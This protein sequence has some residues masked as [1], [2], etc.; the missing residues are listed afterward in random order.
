VVAAI[1]AGVSTLALAGC[2]SWAIPMVWV[3]NVW[4][5]LDLL[6]AIYDGQIGVGIDPG[7]LGAAFFI[8]TVVVP[9]LLVFAWAHLLAATAVKAVKRRSAVEAGS[10][11]EAVMREKYDWI[12][13]DTT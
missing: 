7:S 4:G 10:I 2:A 5:T 8:P 1:L 13:G 11:D 12:H 9:P 3:F 6:H